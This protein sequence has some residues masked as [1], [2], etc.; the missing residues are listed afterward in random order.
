MDVEI[1]KLVRDKFDLN[2]ISR[3]SRLPPFSVTCRLNEIRKFISQITRPRGKIIHPKRD[4]WS[5][6]VYPCIIAIIVH[7][8][9]P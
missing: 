5:T 9:W 7:F 1:R 6:P 2:F 4:S 3:S 8:L